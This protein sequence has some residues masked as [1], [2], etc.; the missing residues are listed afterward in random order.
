MPNTRLELKFDTAAAWANRA[1]AYRLLARAMVTNQ[2]RERLL[3]MAEKLESRCR[4]AGAVLSIA[5][6]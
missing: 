2:S 5:E 4:K 1:R 6:D 3:H